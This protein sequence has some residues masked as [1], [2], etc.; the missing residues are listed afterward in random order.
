MIKSLLFSFF[1][2]MIFSNF[3]L[4]GLIKYGLENL[5]VSRILLVFN[6]EPK[7]FHFTCEFFPLVFSNFFIFFFF[8]NESFFV[9]SKQYSMMLFKNYLFQYIQSPYAF[10]Y[11]DN[12]K[13]FRKL[14]VSFALKLLVI[15][16]TDKKGLPIG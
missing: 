13:F 12:I 10:Y 2:S 6:A 14:F 4:V 5:I 1:V 9:V 8:A 11:F 7:A 3:I 15:E 16:T